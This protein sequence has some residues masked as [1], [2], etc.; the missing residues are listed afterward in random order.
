M[1]PL[2]ALALKYFT[3]A[4][5]AAH[6]SCEHH[7]KLLGI[8]SVGEPE[9][10]TM[11]DTQV[12]LPKASHF[13]KGV[14]FGLIIHKSPFMVD[15]KDPLVLSNYILGLLEVNQGV[16]GFLIQVHVEDVEAVVESINTHAEKGAGRK[17]TLYVGQE[18]VEEVEEVVEGG[19]GRGKEKPH[20]PLTISV[21]KV[22]IQPGKGK[23]KTDG[24]FPQPLTH[25]TR[26]VCTADP[27]TKIPCTPFAPKGSGSVSGMGSPLPTLFR[28]SG[29]FV[30][31]LG[32]HLPLLGRPRKWLRQSPSGPLIGIQWIWCSTL[33]TSWW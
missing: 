4:L 2:F 20:N 27:E 24:W 33:G 5:A 11:G 8:P 26:R 10:I 14:D 3:M 18:E 21:Q 25:N 28:G 12:R 29:S 32:Q 30:F 19:G 22:R 16:A 23:G 13:E 7:Q 31:L 1:F 6:A 9:G 15:D 17:M